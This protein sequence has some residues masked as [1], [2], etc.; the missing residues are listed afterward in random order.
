MLAPLLE[1]TTTL[2]LHLIVAYEKKRKFGGGG[3]P[4][5]A[6][7]P[8][9]RAIQLV[10][11][12]IRNNPNEWQRHYELGFINYVE[13]KD[14]CKAADAFARGSRL[15]NT[16]QFLK[17]L[18]G[19]G[20]E[21]AG[22]I[23]TARLMWQSLLTNPLTIPVFGRTPPLTAGAFKR[24]KSSPAWKSSL[25]LTKEKTGHFPVSFSDLQTT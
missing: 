6:D 17:P 4:D 8:L 23:A 1:I 19:H 14:Y 16:N 5:R 10:E 20:A 12:G 2:I 13:L 11:Y 22:D 18:A 7:G 21:H 9:I 15:P 24:M 25:R 3:A